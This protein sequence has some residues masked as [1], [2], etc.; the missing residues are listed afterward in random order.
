MGLGL[1]KK[2]E[3]SEKV[4]S[5]RES[6]NLQQQTEEEQDLDVDGNAVVVCVAGVERLG[7]G[8][9]L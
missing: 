9:Q 5:L 1:G 6:W 4:P 3:R 7:A 2:I 8:E